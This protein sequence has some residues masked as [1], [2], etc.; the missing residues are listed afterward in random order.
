M[1]AHLTDDLSGLFDGT[2]ANGGGRSPPQ[3][4]FIS[5]SGQTVWG[6][7]DILHPLSGNRLDGYYQARITLDSAAEAG[8][9]KVQN[10]FL[11]DEAGNNQSF[12]PTNSPALSGLCFTV[13]NSRSDTRAPSLASISL[14][15]NSLDIGAG[16]TSL[17]VTAHLTDNLS[18]LFDGTYANGGGGSPPQIWFISPSEQTV[19]GIFDILHP[20]SGDRLDG[21]YQARITLDSAA[22]AGVWKVQNVFLSDEAGNNQ[23][24]TP[25]NSP[26]LSGL[27]FTVANSRS[28]T[29]PPSLASISLSSNSLD[30][31]AG[32]TSLFVTAH[33]TDNLSGLF[34]GTY[35]NGG[36][37]SPPQIWFISSSGQT[38]W[39]IF[40]ILHLL[41]GDRLDGSLSTSH[42][43]R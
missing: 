20:L 15:S 4:W 13:A 6:I 30:L 26:A 22:E 14:S 28:D 33:L 18:G 3:I 5:P 23:S 34:D 42:M 37:G 2:Y 25:T 24:F 36:G 40:D 16:Q 39:G 12:T 32:Q 31:G 29:T 9:W 19:W 11:S 17:F 41:S 35:A 21:Y 8:V 10:V 38:V 43:L 7:F 27:S 1:T